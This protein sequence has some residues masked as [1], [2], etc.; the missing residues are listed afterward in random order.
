MYCNPFEQTIKCDEWSPIL[1]IIYNNIWNNFIVL[2]HNY[3]IMYNIFKNKHYVIILHNQ[4]YFNYVF[5]CV[6]IN[7][8]YWLH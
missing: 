8:I 1:N 6:I 2:N 3:I 5:N 4:L 7:I